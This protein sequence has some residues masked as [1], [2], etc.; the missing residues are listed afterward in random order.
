VLAKGLFNSDR[1]KS[2]KRR[3][4]PGFTGR[5]TG[6]PAKHRQ[7]VPHFGGIFRGARRLRSCPI[8]AKLERT[9]SNHES[10]ISADESMSVFR[11]SWTSGLSS[12]GATQLASIQVD[13]Q[14]LAVEKRD[15]SPNVGRALRVQWQSVA[16]R[17]RGLSGLPRGKAR[18]RVAWLPERTPD[19]RSRECTQVAEQPSYQH[20][21]LPTAPGHS[22]IDPMT[23]GSQPQ[24]PSGDA[25]SDPG[26]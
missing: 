1:V 25:N 21:R 5:A 16:L 2:V 17:L 24:P 22:S 23:A 3:S 8:S 10:A 6:P 13:D 4:T 12:S 14:G 7:S 26:A 19:P 11:K 18:Q 9:A 20:R 15:S